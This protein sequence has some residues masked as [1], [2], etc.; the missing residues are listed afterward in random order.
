VTGNLL[1]VVIGMDFVNDQ[2][3]ELT[4][5]GRAPVDQFEWFDLISD[6]DVDKV[7]QDWEGMMTGGKSDGVQFRLKK[8]WV[9]QDGKRSNIWVQSSSY[10]EFDENGKVI[11]MTASSRLD[12]HAL[13]LVGIMGTLFDISQFKW[14]ESVQRR[15]IEEA[16][17]AKRQQEKYDAL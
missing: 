17:E 15:R 6:E 14:A 16:W 3:F 8:T 11:S 2:F 13:K 10:P 12:F 7:K 4:V 9:D 5:H 1:K